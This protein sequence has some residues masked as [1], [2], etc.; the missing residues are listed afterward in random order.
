MQPGRKSLEAMVD[1]EGFS[2]EIFRRR[3]NKGESPTFINP[4]RFPDDDHDEGGI[5]HGYGWDRRIW[6]RD[7]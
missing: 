7:C 6:G 2:E 5:H 1:N 4:D 3:V